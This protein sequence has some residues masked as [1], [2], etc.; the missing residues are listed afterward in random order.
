MPVL[1][2]WLSNT[3]PT[4]SLSLRHGETVRLSA[5]ETLHLGSAL[6]HAQRRGNDLQLLLIGE[7]DDGTIAVVVEGYF[8][9][10]NTAVVA[11]G[12]PDQTRPLERSDFPATE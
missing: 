11:T 2:Q 6:R 10:G 7:G 12:T 5:D 8:A 9:T 4:R 3:Q 1:V